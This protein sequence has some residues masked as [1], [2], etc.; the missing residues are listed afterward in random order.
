MKLIRKV[1]SLLCLTIL[2]LP[3][4][5]QDD[6]EDL[7]V[8][9]V[10]DGR[11]LV[12]AYISPFMKS[13]SLGM[14]QGWY[15]TAKA[16]KIA[17]L[18]L[19]IT[20]NGMTVPD[21]ERM[22]NP[23]T[24]GLT[25]VELDPSSPGYP[26]MPTI[27][28]SEDRPVLRLQDDPSKTFEGPPGLGLKENLGVNFV[29]VPIAH[30][31]IGLP[32]GTDL[33]IRFTPTLEFDDATTFKIF[34]IGIMHDIKQWIPGVK[35]MPFDLSGFVGFTRLT[36]ES[37]LDADNPENLDQ[38]GVFSINATTVQGIISKKL[39][40][41]TVYGGVGYNIARSNIALTG[42]YDLNGD[43]DEDDEFETNPVDLQFGAS[44]PRLT[45]GMR[46]K[47][48]VLTLHADYTV[49]KYKCLTVGIG[50]SVR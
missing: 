13:I 49:Q 8:E 5:A 36:L 25:Q 15:N 47:L 2:A 39:S 30:L 6:L 34:G 26:E 1:F 24:L 32:K 7:L 48:A 23:A 12:G 14:N 38:M 11:K 40:I 4:F 45:A 16:H 44:G 42:K 50:L 35:L 46:L 22:F 41:L 31:G 19:T 21:D 37:Q 28:G 3:S 29:P 9:S 27:L 20:M 18:D 17:G 10:E 33:K 43:N